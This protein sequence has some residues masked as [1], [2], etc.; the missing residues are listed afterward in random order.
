MGKLG[1]AKLACIVLMFCGAAV[2]ASSAQTFTSLVSFDVANGSAPYY[3]TLVQGFD[4]NFYGTTSQG[5]TGN[6]GTVFRITPAGT[7]TTL[8]SFD[9]TDGD[10][11]LEGPGMVQGSD[12]SFYGTAA[13]GGT[14][15]GGT[16]FKMTAGGTLTTLY[17]FCSQTNCADGAGPV[18]GLLQSTDGN[19]YGTAAVAG[20][21]GG[22]TVFKITAGGTLTT[23]YN[24]CSQANCADGIYPVGLMQGTN[25]DFYGTTN[26]GGNTACTSG[27]G[28]IFEITPTGALTT[29]HSFDG[30]DGAFP[31]WLIQAT[32]GNF[33]GTT[34]SGGANNECSGGCGTVFKLTPGGTLTTLY[35]FCS[36]ASC[37]DGVTPGAGLVQAADGNFYG[38]TYGG[39]DSGWGTLFRIAPSGILTTLYNFCA[40][41]NCNDGAQPEGLV[42]GTD[43]SF[44]GTTDAG[45]TSG[46]CSNGCGT[47]YSLSAGLR[48]FVETQPT[49]GKVGK[50]VII[51]GSMLTG[52]T[53]VSFNGI[54]ATFTVAKS[55][56]IKTI[57]PT[58]AT[59]GKVEV[60]TP[61]KTLKSNVAFRVTPQIQSF[62]PTSGPVGTVVTITGV[63]LTQTKSVAFGGL[64]ATQFTV[65]SDT[66]VQATVPT[67]AKTG[68]IAITTSGGTAIS[69][70]IFTVTS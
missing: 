17:N 55:T 40:Q 16:V 12:G 68:H 48:P 33:Y 59:T 50:A 24:F 36:Q 47:V 5:G 27:C 20:A 10:D 63:S 4:G 54:A 7:L 1:S 41:S 56:E 69:S 62:T 39:G 32:D 8:H 26:Y 34:S 45:G 9:D 60:T 42:Q 61:T 30:T 28:T 19:F 44:Y 15:G 2:I 3:T 21:Y 25:G 64:K 43:G 31:N 22:G 6:Y 35:N 11:P 65:V 70:G 23:L 52:T 49:S 57:V 66:E 14:Y 51:L 37:N 46:E 18:A 29:L 13:E 67:G 38:T 58:G 53:S